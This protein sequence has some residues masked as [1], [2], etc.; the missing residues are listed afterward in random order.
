MKV[1][2]FIAV[3]LTGFAAGT[4]L[5]NSLEACDR[6][7][8]GHTCNSC[9]P[10]DD[11]GLLDRLDSLL[12]RR[13]PQLPPLCDPSRP[14]F[15]GVLRC[16]VAL[17]D[18]C[19]CGSG[20]GCGCELN[21]P[22]CG[23]ELSEPTC[24]C[25]LTEANCGVEM[26]NEG[27]SSHEHDNSSHSSSGSMFESQPAT[28]LDTH[29][30]RIPMSNI[31]QP[32]PPLLPPYKEAIEPFSSNSSDSVVPSPP[33]ERVPQN[34][35]TIP[36]GENKTPPLRDSEV[37]PFQ[38]E[39]AG[40]LRRLPTRQVQHN[41]SQRVYRQNY[42][43]QASKTLMHRSISDDGRGSRQVSDLTPT[44]ASGANRYR[45]PEVIT[46]SGQA[47]TKS[48]DTSTASYYDNAAQRPVQRVAVEPIANPLRSSR[49]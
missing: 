28:P 31:P 15:P 10:T 26:S 8:G 3:C 32:V 24:G 14:L 38:D 23:C 44:S 49:R 47:P 20:P 40:R 7:R 18:C 36:K 29:R 25:E 6:C 27:C 21:G 39:S 5:V 2:N 4:S 16:P 33:L 1:R 13:Q 30:G 35:P 43:P 45:M 22:G 17:G 42:D 11:R 34:A 19:Q 37:D 46:A 9:G 48:G 41:Q 12:Q